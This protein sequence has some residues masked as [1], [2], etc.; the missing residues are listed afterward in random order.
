MNE[1]R[2]LIALILTEAN[3]PIVLIYLVG[4]CRISLLA[5]R[6]DGATGH[7][8]GVMFAGLFA[9]TC[10]Q[11]MSK[12][13]DAVIGFPAG[14]TAMLLVFVALNWYHHRLFEQK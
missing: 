12:R 8:F 5:G 2:E 7:K 1:E 4:A 13:I 10:G 11:H 9:A 3:L 6:L 14:V